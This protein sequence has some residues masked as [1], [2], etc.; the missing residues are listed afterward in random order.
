MKLSILLT[1]VLCFGTLVQCQTESKT[2]KLVIGTGTSGALN[3]EIHVYKFDSQTGEVDFLSKTS[4][5]NNS[6]YLAVSTDGKN[7]YSVN[8]VNEGT[9]SSFSLDQATGALTLLNRVS[10]G[11]AGPCY[12]SVDDNKRY[13]VVAN[14][15][16]GR[17]TAIPI[18]DNGSLSDNMQVIQE[19]GN[20]VN[21]RRQRGPHVHS[22]VL[23]PDNNFVFTSNLGTDKVSAYRF[24]TTRPVNPLTPADPAYFAIE[25]GS[26]PRHFTFHPNAKYAYLIA[27]LTGTIVAFDYNNGR[28]TEKQTI[29]MLSL[30]FKGRVGA[31]DIHVSPDGNFLYGSNRGDA[32]EIVIYS[33]NAAGELAYVGSH[34]T[35][36][37]GP[38]NFAI[39]PTGN[40]LL[41]ANQNSDEIIFF[42]RDRKTGL[43][44]PS[45]KS[46][47]VG[48][49]VCLKFH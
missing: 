33:I 41:V 48:K 13:V 6:S 18:N 47:K 4:G 20:S 25:P 34:S 8:E 16:S 30:D 46:I 3:D 17:L 27:E 23:S 42:R 7:V 31:A 49:P 5:H 22:A 35:M 32:N 44:T 28:L 43:L 11:G 2:Y 38:R 40:F 14:Y 1:L 45:E 12:I 26:G 29:T 37:Q 39:D 21:E 15:G 36:G 19:E 24:E 10:S 9:V